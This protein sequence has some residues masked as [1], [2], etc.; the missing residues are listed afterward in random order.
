LKIKSIF[1]IDGS[2]SKY[3]PFNE[4]LEEGKNQVLERIPYF[5]QKIQILSNLVIP[6]LIKA[7][8]T[9]FACDMSSFTISF[10]PLFASILLLRICLRNFFSLLLI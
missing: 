6:L 2:Y 8:A 5:E 10:A 9:L 1:V 3:I 7:T 4:L